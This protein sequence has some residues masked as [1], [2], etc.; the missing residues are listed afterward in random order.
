MNTNENAEILSATNKRVSEI[1]DNVLKDLQSSQSDF[2]KKFAATQKEIDS[3]G[4]KTNGF[5]V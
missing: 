5:I 2:D 4:R 3:R 1:A